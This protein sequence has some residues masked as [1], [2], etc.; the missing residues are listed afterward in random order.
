MALDPVC[1]LPDSS[2]VPTSQEPGPASVT[3]PAHF[4]RAHS[5][6]GPGLPPSRVS[7][8]QPALPGAK[9][10][11]RESVWTREAIS[12]PS[13][14]WGTEVRQSATGSLPCL[15][16]PCRGQAWVWISLVTTP[17]LPREPRGAIPAPCRS[18]HR[19]WSSSGKPRN[20]TTPHRKAMCPISR[21]HGPTSMVRDLCGGWEP[22]CFGVL[23]PG[24]PVT[25]QPVG[26]QG[27]VAEGS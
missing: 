25:L 5:R 1:S 12:Q 21:F 15:P 2:A 3:E 6:C 19:L 27:S 11:V 4:L 16:C 26:T 17:E 14:G 7:S 9:A 8:P 24:G 13:W 23:N 20:T 22:V 10:K 18:S